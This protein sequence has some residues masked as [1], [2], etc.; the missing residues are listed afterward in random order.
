VT[1]SGA[2]QLFIER[3]Q[4]VAPDFVLTEPDAAAV[5]E[6]CTRLD[7][8][9]MA[10]ELAAARIKLFPPRALVRRLAHAEDAEADHEATWL[11]LSGQDRDLPARHQT[12][13]RAISWSYDLLAADE[14]TVLRRLAVFVGGCSIDAAEAVGACGISGGLEIIAGLLDKSLLGRDEQPD[15]EPRLRMLETIRAYGAHQLRI[16]HEIDEVRARHARY[17][18]SLVESAAPVLFGPH[19]QAWFARF[20]CERPNL[21]A[22]EAWAGRQDGSRARLAWSR[23][24]GRKTRRVRNLPFTARARRHDR[25]QSG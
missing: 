5:A 11:L 13:I 6:I 17:Y 23:A 14:Q 8:L 1:T 15:G 12:L 2:G 4:T 19:Q 24:D 3:A 7:G 25:A 16:R 21:L 22:V 10:I 9:P 18:V 20:E